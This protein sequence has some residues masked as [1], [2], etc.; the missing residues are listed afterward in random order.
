MD[1]KGMM[2]PAVMMGDIQT[3]IEDYRS[4]FSFSEF[5]NSFQVN[6][7]RSF[8]SVCLLFYLIT[9]RSYVCID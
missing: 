7:R 5:F 8:I 9:M 1:K 4:N 6:E 2:D 3:I